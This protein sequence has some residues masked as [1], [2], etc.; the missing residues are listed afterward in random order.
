MGVV[1]LVFDG[2]GDLT[3]AFDIQVVIFRLAEWRVAA[4]SAANHRLR[5]TA[6]G[7]Q[8]SAWEAQFL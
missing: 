4:T 1:S 3:W 5:A 2:P 8:L 7:E 6:N